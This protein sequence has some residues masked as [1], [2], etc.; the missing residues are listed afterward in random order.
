ML[1]QLVELAL[2]VAALLL[3]MLH[4]LAAATAAAAESCRSRCMRRHCSCWKPQPRLQHPILARERAQA[5][6]PSVLRSRPCPSQPRLQP[7]L[8]QAAQAVASALQQC[9]CLGLGL[10]TLPW[11]VRWRAFCTATAVG[12]TRTGIAMRTASGMGA[13][14]Q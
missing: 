8:Q 14:R 11:S 2:P 7:L 6:V 1:Q 4:G 10:R 9:L 5:P 3:V 12:G 13:G